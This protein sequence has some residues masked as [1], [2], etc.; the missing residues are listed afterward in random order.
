MPETQLDAYLPLLRLLP[1]ET[2]QDL[3]LYALNGRTG[4]VMPPCCSDRDLFLSVQQGQ[5]WLESTAGNRVLQARESEFLPAGT[6]FRL[7]SLTDSRGRLIMP[8]EA[9]INFEAR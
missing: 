5:L 9:Q 1:I 8:A 6:R 2:G 4:Q 7:E 3:K